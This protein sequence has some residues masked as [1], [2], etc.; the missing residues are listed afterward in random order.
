M[1][2]LYFQFRD[3]GSISFWSKLFHFNIKFRFIYICVIFLLDLRF[4]SI[5]MSISIEWVAL[6]D[7]FLR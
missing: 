7:F 2:L 5:L 6:S 3:G 1:I 4:S